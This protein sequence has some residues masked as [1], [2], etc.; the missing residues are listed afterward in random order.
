[1][2]FVKY[3]DV[4]TFDYVEKNLYCICALLST[5]D[6]M[7]HFVRKRELKD[8]ARRLQNVMKLKCFI[9]YYWTR[10]SFGIKSSCA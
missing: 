7:D 2:A 1:M 5:S 9:F 4:S 10:E 3:M 8:G 6:E